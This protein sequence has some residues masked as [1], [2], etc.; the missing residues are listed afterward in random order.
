M[1]VGQLGLSGTGAS[2]A[3]KGSIGGVAGANA[4]LSGRRSPGPDPAYL[5]NDCIIAASNCGLLPPPPTTTVQQP[6]TVPTT[7]TVQL[8]PFEFLVVE[9]QAP[10]ELSILTVVPNLTATLNLVT[11]QPVTAREQPDADT[12]VINIFDEERLCTETT[13]PSLT[14]RERC[15]QTR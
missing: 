3:L 8:P 13:G 11:P 10:S 5:F 14:A 2:A 4:A 7:T 9:P 12:P 6:P 15:E 1:D